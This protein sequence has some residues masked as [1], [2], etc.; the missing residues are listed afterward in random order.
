MNKIILICVVLV[1]TLAQFAAAD[2]PVQSGSRIKVR[3]VSTSDGASGQLGWYDEAKKVNCYFMMSSDQK[4]RCLPSDFAVVL[5][6]MYSDVNC[7]EAVALKVQPLINTSFALLPGSD[8]KY[9]KLKEKLS[10]TATYLKSPN[11]NSCTPMP[12]A[13]AGELYS[14]G[15]QVDL[16]EFQEAEVRIQ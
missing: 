8:A 1:S 16:A 5:Q 15:A 10:K 9:F 3:T 7:V 13:P 12:F 2:V 4:V 14:I 11:G 6:N